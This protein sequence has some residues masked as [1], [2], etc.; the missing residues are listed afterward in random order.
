[1]INAIIL[2]AGRGSR[3]DATTDA[4]PKCLIRIAGRRLL[5]RQIESL[6]KGGV[7]NI[8]IVTGYGAAHLSREPLFRFHN[9]LWESTDM[10][11]SLKCATTWLSNSPCIVS[12]SD[13][14]YDQGAIDSLVTSDA[15][16]AI[17]FD[18]KW[19]DQWKARFSDP[20]SD[21]ETFQF[22]KAGYLTE[23]GNKADNV[24][25]IQGQYMGLLRFT[26]LGWG[27]FLQAISSFS[28]KELISLHITTVLN[29]IVQI[30]SVKIQVLPFSGVWG[31]IDT[32]RDLELFQNR[33]L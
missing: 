30:G 6:S 9:T 24:S 31:E 13:I 3:L 14:F 19:L 1:M 21:A 22:N 33:M 5:D 10:V 8:G 4:L 12:Y 32:P 29:R 2:A 11:A 16:L 27:A 23:I 25:E 28:T 7:D 17:T 18:P 15:D 26:P 20:L